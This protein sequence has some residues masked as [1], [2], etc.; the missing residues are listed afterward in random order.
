MQDLSKAKLASLV[1]LTTMAGYAVAPGAGNLVNLLW[2]TVGTTLCVASANTINQWLEV[3]FDAQMSRTRNRP[4]VRHALNPLRAF[5]LGIFSGVAGISVLS[6]VNPTVAVLGGANIILYTCFYTPLKR[7]SIA[8]TWVGAAV[9][10]IPPIMGWV[11]CTGSLDA[12]AWVLAAILFSWQFPHFN[13]LSWNLRADYS[14]AGYKMMSVLDPALNG[15]VSFRHAL[16]LFPICYAAPMI[17]MTSWIFAIDSSI[18]NG[19][20]AYGA[21]RFWRSAN[22]KTARELFFLS[23]IHLPILMALLMIHKL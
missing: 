13:S 19:A 2:T 22:E 9:G 6:F 8:N 12:G 1:V 14:K 16:Y 3:P 11:A 7:M 18:V 17:G 10:A 21:W 23:L 20:L 5:S 4:L 15:R